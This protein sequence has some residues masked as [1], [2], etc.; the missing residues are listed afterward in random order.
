MFRIRKQK[1]EE[2][3]EDTKG[4]IRSRKS[5]MD[6]KITANNRQNFSEY[7]N[8]KTYCSGYVKNNNKNFS[9]YA[10]QKI[11]ELHQDAKI[12]PGRTDWMHKQQIELTG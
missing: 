1:K 8:N 7:R 11:D 3:C 9:R 12:T 2:K 10:E 5:K 4:T 6:T